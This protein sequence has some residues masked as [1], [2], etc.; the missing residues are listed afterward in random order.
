MAPTNAQRLAYE[1]V[2]PWIT[3]MAVAEWD[4]A[5]RNTLVKEASA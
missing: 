3:G 2:H 5:Q 4:T 1:A